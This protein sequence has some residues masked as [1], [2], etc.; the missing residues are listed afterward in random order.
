MILDLIRR[1]IPIK[2]RQSIGLWTAS[3]AGR[4]KWLLYPYMLIICGCLP[5]N[6]TLL[7][8]GKCAIL[9]KGR[10]ILSPRDGIFTSWEVLQDNI[11][12]K[13]HTPHYGDTVIDVGAYVGMFTI[14][15]A[16]QVGKNGRVIA[17][18]P[19]KPNL[20]YLRDNIGGLDNVEVIAVA[21]GASTG[22]GKL[23]L[24][25]ASPCHTMIN[26]KGS[27][28]QVLVVTLDDIVSG[29]KIKKV[30]YIKIDAEGYE[31]EILEG[32]TE[33]LKTKGL[34]LAVA[35]YHNLSTGERELP[36]ICRLLTSAGF[37]IHVLK[38]YVYATK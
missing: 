14:K 28:Q 1:I 8:G 29:Y 26:N 9:Y 33:T 2:Y 35:S 25:H 22:T 24:S 36:Y 32:A 37:S 21:V 5:K 4:A 10:K 18:E 6:L 30:N 19:A 23:S 31:L 34:K 12:D 16:L 17:V 38:G 27:K 20:E 13:F 3:Q 15:A 7:P 11:Y